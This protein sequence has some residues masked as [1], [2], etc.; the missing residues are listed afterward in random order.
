MTQISLKVGLGER[1]YDITIGPGLID[2]A[3]SLLG[4][5]A[6]GRHIVVVSDDQVASLH[7]QRLRDGLLPIAR[8]L[9]QFVLAY[10]I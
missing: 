6:N 5:I 2:Q 8:K 4:E 7:L 1:A 9:D 3:G 10:L